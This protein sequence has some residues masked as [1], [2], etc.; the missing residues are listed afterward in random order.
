MAQTVLSSADTA[1]WK[2]LTEKLAGVLSVQC[3]TDGAAVREVHVLSD[4]SRSPKQIVRDIQPAL[5]AQFQ[6]E[7]DHRVIS[8]AQIPGLPTAVQQRRLIC[9]KLELSTGRAG[10][11]AAVSLRIGDI[12]HRGTAHSDLS[13]A[14]RSR[15]IAQATADAI[16]QFLA[17][18]CRF[19]LEELRQV[20]M[21]SQ[22]AVMVGLRLEQSGKT[23]SLLG[24][25]YL[26]ED[27]NFS[28]ALATLDGVNR[29]ILTLAF[30]HEG[31]VSS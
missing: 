19:C 28:V 8:V 29:R 16:N 1:Q 15:A 24:A 20:P 26:G 5:L 23:E 21:G 30:A 14:G 27:P 11:D 4:Q 10:V 6:L 7:L 22:T 2:A 9:D 12:S 31:S 18:G 17:A 13:S 3:V 25:C